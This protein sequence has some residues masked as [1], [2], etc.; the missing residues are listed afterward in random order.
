MLRA[1]HSDPLLDDLCLGVFPVDKIPPVMKYPSCLIANT[2]PHTKPGQH[3]VLLVFPTND[4]CEYFDS[5]GRQPQGKFD[6][7][8]E[9]FQTLLMSHVQVQSSLS[10]VCGAHCLFVAYMRCEHRGLHS[11]KFWSITH[12]IL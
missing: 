3:W 6:K 10:S 2:D 4:E 7:I 12:Q 9:L 8:L 1:V 5:Y 11:N